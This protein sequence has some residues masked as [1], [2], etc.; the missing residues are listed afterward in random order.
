MAG[1]PVA[2]VGDFL[3][4][5]TMAGISPMYADCGVGLVQEFSEPY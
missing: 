2:G 4:N 3:G 5:Q 1:E